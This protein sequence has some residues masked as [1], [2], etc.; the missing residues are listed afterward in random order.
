M[1]CHRVRYVFD[2]TPG[3]SGLNAGAPLAWRSANA[4]TMR[5]LRSAT[6]FIAACRRSGSGVGEAAEV[7]GFG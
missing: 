5:R 6:R 7:D 2:T 3:S 1:C 4:C